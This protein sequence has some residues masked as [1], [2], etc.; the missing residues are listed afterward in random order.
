MPDWL[1][2]VISS[3]LA[4]LGLV[5]SFGAG[6]DKSRGRTAFPPFAVAIFLEVAALAIVWSA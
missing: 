2:F 1:A 3:F 6:M 5:M 4:F